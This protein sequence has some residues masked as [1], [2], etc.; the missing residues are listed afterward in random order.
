L[1]IL[2]GFDEISKEL[3][4]RTITANIRA[5]IDCYTAPIFDG[6]KILITSRTHFF[7]TGD[8]SRLLQRLE[9]PLL[10]QL[11]RIPRGQVLGHLQDATKG[12]QERELLQKLSQMHDP[13]G[14]GTKPL[15][16]Q[17]L[18]DTLHELPADL[19]EVSVYENY[20]RR[21][22]ERKIEMLDDPE[23]R[24]VRGNSID[25][26]LGALGILAEELQRSSDPYVS[27]KNMRQVTGPFA[28]LLWRLT[29]DDVLESDAEARLGTR[30]L[31][32][33]VKP[34]EGDGQWLVDFCHRSIR[35]YFVARR[36]G[37]CLSQ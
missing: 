22:L 20:A 30:S 14:L 21:S 18:K 28:E 9:M 10:L 4:P 19:D 13:I 26:L 8:A 17:M 34:L 27:L 29:G 32:S 7:E 23:V 16:L 24:S 2:D 11:G 25:Q 3:D 33:R 5:L 36:F 6:S 1:V 15:F 35:E 12:P 37:R 31:L